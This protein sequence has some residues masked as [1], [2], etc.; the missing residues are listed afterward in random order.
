VSGGTVGLVASLARPATPTLAVAA[1]VLVA[2]VLHAG[3]NALAKGIGDA[4][5]AF[6]LINATV[7]VVGAATLAVAGFP[8]EVALPFLAGSLGIHIAYNVGLLNAYRVADL[9]QAYPLARGLA[10]LLVAVVAAATIG[11]RL[12]VPQ[13]VGLVA[14]A[15]GLASLGWPAQGAWGRERRGIGLALLTG[16]AIAGYSVTDGLGARHD[17]SVLGYAGALFLLEGGTLAIA[18]PLARR[19]LPRRVRDGGRVVLAQG[20][21]AGALSWAAYALVLWAQTRVA[22]ATVSALRETSVVMAALFGALFLREGHTRRRLLAA[23]SVV[24][25]VVVLVLA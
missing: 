17:P 2:A 7:A 19:D 3:W 4:L 18:L 14:I 13:V 8:P 10:P 11:E 6:W 25:G 20:L 21:T 16:V 22:L 12:D 9:S 1:L 15:A 5:V 24:A 23:L